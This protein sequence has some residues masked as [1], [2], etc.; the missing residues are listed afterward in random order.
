MKKVQRIL[1]NWIETD[2][3][4]FIRTFLFS[5]GFG[6]CLSASFINGYCLD[7]YDSVSGYLPIALLLALL[8]GTLIAAGLMVYWGYRLHDTDRQPVEKREAADK[9]SVKIWI[10][11]AVAI[12]AC[13]VL[14][15]LAYYPAVFA[16]DAETQ[17]YQTLTGDYSTH[18]PLIHTLW[19]G[20]C[21]KLMY[22]VA[23]MNAGMALYALSQ[24]VIM[25]LIFGWTVSE[26]AR[27]GLKKPLLILYA[28]FLAVFPVNGILAISVTKDVV[29]SG[30]VLVLVML[31]RRAVSGLSMSAPS[32]QLL[33]KIAVS[34][35]FIC[36]LRNN[37][38]YALVIMIFFIFL[39]V[40]DATRPREYRGIII[41]IVLG[42]A[43]GCIIN[44]GVKY[45]LGATKGS[46]REALSIPIQQM[47]RVRSL[48][49]DKLDENMIDRLDLLLSP[50]ADILY[51]EHL[52][53][54]VKR[55]VNLKAPGQFVLTWAELLVR[56]PGAYLDAWLLTTEGSWYV[57]DVSVNEIYG[58]GY[59]FGYLSTD[60]R[61]M[62][63]G[64]EVVPD[65][66]LPWL[67]D[68][69]E[70]LVTDNVFEG[71]PVVRLIFAPAVYVWICLA[72]LYGAFV[73]KSKMG[74]CCCSYLVAYYLTVLLGP[75]ILVRYMYPYMIAVILP[76][77]G[78]DDN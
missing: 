34:T 53:D 45:S 68:V 38:P 39:R 49:S 15:W 55:E 73:R 78:Y 48:Y 46:P 59:G 4:G 72:Y 69:L 42:V 28:V 22:D 66:R 2:K 26:A 9:V 44:T 60:T 75:A 50:E 6:F 19:L 63:A 33:C 70:R 65:S 76:L 23:G 51:N 7:T 37:A 74:L 64:F 24:M 16:Y 77:L 10:I 3:T 61:T 43:A 25:A 67:K 41:A 32:K 17:L 40:P 62:P 21:M 56:F 58:K 54:P 11:A 47:A 29:F 71:V 27:I 8:A 20:A 1:K 13:W 31:V 30:G 18:H 12:F 57:Y 14:I 5:E 36:L 35:A 52:A